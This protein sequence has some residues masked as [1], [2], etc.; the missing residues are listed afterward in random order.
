M[1]FIRTWNWY[2]EYIKNWAP[3]E[4]PSLSIN[5]YNGK[6]TYNIALGSLNQDGMMKVYSDNSKR[7]NA[8]ISLNSELNK[9][10]S[11]RTGVM[12]PS[13]DYVK[14]FNY[15]TDLY[16][17]MCSLYRWTPMMRYGT[18]EAQEFRNALTDQ[19]NAPIT[20]KEHEY[21]RLTGG[22]TIKPRKDLTLDID[23]AYRSVENRS[24]KYGTPSLTSGY[25]IFTALP[26]VESVRDSYGR[27]RSAA[28]YDYVY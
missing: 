8:N 20:T 18:F 16:D 11:I 6:T 4:N 23:V 2:D 15:N 28:T 14:P 10:V 12:V 7:Y 3:H 13:S 24:K 21:L 1:F 22:A 19:K 5:G 17:P 26:S 27:Y 9:Y 25:E